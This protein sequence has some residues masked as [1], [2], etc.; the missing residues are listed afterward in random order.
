MAA[1]EAKL[2]Q[3]CSD[4]DQGP[5]GSCTTLAVLRRIEITTVISQSYIDSGEK[6]NNFKHVNE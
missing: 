3:G 1:K 2:E 4:V 6:S 5:A